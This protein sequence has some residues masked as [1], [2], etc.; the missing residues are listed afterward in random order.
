[1]PQ[2]PETTTKEEQRGKGDHAPQPVA[3]E[4][5]RRPIRQVVGD[6]TRPYRYIFPA[7]L[8]VFAVFAYPIAR[9]FWTSLHIDTARVPDM[10]FVGA[11]NY[12]DLWQDDAFW[13]SFQNS[14]IFVVGTIAIGMVMAMIF[15][16]VLHHAPWS[17]LKRG[18]RALSLAPWLISG[19]A[20]A[21]MFRF[22]FNSDVGLVGFL[23]VLPFM[24]AETWLGDPVRA[25]IVIVIANTWYITPFSTL[26]LLAGMQTIDPDLYE[27]ASIDGATGVQAFRF[28]TLPALAP[29]IALTLVY[30]SFASWNTFDLVLTMTAGGPGRATEVMALYMYRLA[31]TNLDF[32]SAAAVMMVLLLLNVFFSIFYLKTFRID[33]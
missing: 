33:D 13:N 7:S 6:A 18:L 27:A 4:H 32:S 31:F 3:A 24:D 28:I 12:I 30:F 8:L 21:T 29:H 16:L 9:G 1:M 10:P 20:A 19:V 2:L 25:V 26:I 11:E 14:V 15:A 17:P 5:A 23:D 22:L